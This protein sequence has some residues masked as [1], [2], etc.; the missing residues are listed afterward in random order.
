M[1]NVKAPLRRVVSSAPTAPRPR[2]AGASVVHFLPKF[3]GARGGRRPSCGGDGRGRAGSVPGPARASPAAPGGPGSAPCGCRGGHGPVPRPSTAPRHPPEAVVRG[4]CWQGVRR[5][6][7]GAR[8][9]V[10]GPPRPAGG[11]PPSPRCP[12]GAGDAGSRPRER[13]PLP[14]ELRS[15]QETRGEALPVLRA[16][17]TERGRPGVRP[18]SAR[19]AAVPC[20]CGHWADLARFPAQLLGLPLSVCALAPGVGCPRESG[21]FCVQFIRTL[22]FQEKSIMN[23]RIYNLLVRLI[24]YES[25]RVLRGGKGKKKTVSWWVVSGPCPLLTVMSERIFFPGWGG[26]P[27]VCNTDFS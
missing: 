2:L 24:E 3:G 7:R 19:L 27:L 14:P 15:W 18:G 5:R 21:L 6:R 17:S 1:E 11:S 22:R 4:R 25:P 26:S 10:S 16:L 12:L 13:F 20:R 23:V 8:E 9:G